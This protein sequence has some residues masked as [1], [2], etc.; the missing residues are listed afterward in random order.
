MVMVKVLVFPFSFFVLSVW[1]LDLMSRKH[2]CLNYYQ[3]QLIFKCI[4][5]L[6]LNNGATFL[7]DIWKIITIF[8]LGIKKIWTYNSIAAYFKR[9][10]SWHDFIIWLIRIVIRN[11][12]TINFTHSINFWDHVKNDFSIRDSFFDCCCLIYSMLFV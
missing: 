7:I 11:K 9:T 4:F 12:L 3:S 6:L 10:D 2:L 5:T 8:I 1:Y